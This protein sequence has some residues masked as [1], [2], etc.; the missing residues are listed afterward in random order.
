MVPAKV[1][2]R[3]L[4]AVRRILTM[5]RLF[6]HRKFPWGISHTFLFVN[7][8]VCVLHILR[9]CL[10][11]LTVFVGDACRLWRNRHQAAI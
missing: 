7:V 10:Q 5:N 6:R 9:P 4:C 11:P 1:R 3:V 8:V 2:S